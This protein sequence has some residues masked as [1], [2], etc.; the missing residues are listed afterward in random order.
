LQIARKFGK[1]DPRSISIEVK[2]SHEELGTMVGTTR[3]RISVFMQRFRNLDL[4][5]YNTEHHLIIKEEKLTAYL[6]SIL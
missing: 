5:E 2:M 6:Q 3:P 4:I 1:K